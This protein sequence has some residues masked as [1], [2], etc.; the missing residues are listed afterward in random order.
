[1]LPYQNRREREEQKPECVITLVE[2]TYLFLTVL[3]YF[4]SSAHTVPRHCHVAVLSPMTWIGD[5]RLLR[6]PTWKRLVFRA[7]RPQDLSSVFSRSLSPHYPPRANFAV[8][9]LTK[10]TERGGINLL[11]KWRI[12][13]WRPPLQQRL[14]FRR[15]QSLRKGAYGF[16]GCFACEFAR[17]LIHIIC[18]SHTHT[19]GTGI[20]PSSRSFSRQHIKM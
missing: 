15:Y 18:I 8:L 7:I 1:M 11:D 6:Y 14:H 5:I 12:W 2:C 20:K 4:L 13:D 16:T 9:R 17:T 10:Y 3:H 19:T